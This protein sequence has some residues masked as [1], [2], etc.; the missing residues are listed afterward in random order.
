MKNHWNSW[1]IIVV[2]SIFFSYCAKDE[3]AYCQRIIEGDWTLSFVTADYTTPLTHL[4]A[5]SSEIKGKH[6]IKK[7]KFRRNAKN[8][9]YQ[10]EVEVTWTLGAWTDSISIYNYNILDG[11]NTLRFYE[12]GTT[13]YF[14]RKIYELNFSQA[15]FL[16]IDFEPDIVGE[17]T[18][19]YVK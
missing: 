19:G 12:K 8:A 6:Y 13:A 7:L 17:A 3:E 15:G 1:V 16:K 11:C 18:G 4:V 9:T 14:D 5:D 10:G 2:I